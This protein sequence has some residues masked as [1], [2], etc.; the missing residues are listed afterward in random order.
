MF[1]KTRARQLLKAMFNLEDEHWIAG[2]LNPRT[3]MLK[4]A[5]DIE[6][7]NAHTLVRRELEK[8]IQLQGTEDHHSTAAASTKSPASTPRKKFK[9]Y[10]TKFDDDNELCESNNS[11]TTVKRARQEFELYLQFKLTN[12]TYTKNDNADPLIFWKDQ[13]QVFPNLSILART[14]FCIPASSAAVER[15]FSSAGNII[16]QRRTSISPS[17]VNDMILV[18]SAATNSLI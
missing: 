10:T 3:R 11:V 7:S 14:I 2:V 8:I 6:R 13:E 18:R 4:M 17:T 16:S 15:S 9:S 5:T 12:S 1:F